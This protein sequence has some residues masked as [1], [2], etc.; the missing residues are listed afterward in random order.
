M[1]EIAIL[2]PRRGFTLIELLVVIAIIAVLIG[3]LL[4]AVQ[5]AREAARRAQ[6]INNMKQ[7]GLAVAN[8]ESAIGSYPASYGT[9]AGAAG[10]G[11]SGGSGTWG[12]WSP[13]SQLLPY[14]DQAALYNSI[15]FKLVSHGDANKAGDLAQVTAITTRIASLVCPSA[16]FPPQYFYSGAYPG[17]SYF[18]SV[19]SSLV[20]AGAT[21]SSAP[22]GIFMFGGGSDFNGNPTQGCPPL[23]I[24]DVID[25]TSNTIALGEWKLGDQ[26]P[27]KLS[28][29]DVIG[30]GPGYP[31]GLTDCTDWGSPLM[32]MQQQNYPAFQA[33][34]Q[35]CAGLAPAST[36]YGHAGWEY[37]MSYLGMAWNQG[38]FGWTL[39]N[40]LLA[41]N[42]PY[43]NCRCCSWN[44]DWDCPGMYGLSSFHPGGGNIAFADGSVRFLKS[45]TATFVVWALGSRAN[46]EVVSS[47]T[48]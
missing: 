2:K 29:Q 19:G 27:N 43:P 37:N 21:G 42:S 30:H 10:N 23:G 16:A 22:N 32:N 20:W 40:T 36:T 45:S 3:L 38:M 12:S 48:Y 7:V 18:A 8:Y 6:C 31:F 26:D 24:R 11:W 46:G 33:W 39:G 35:K 5:S 25:G 44:G 17:N 47:D 14:F 9:G 1:E 41:P 4:P 28:V 13:Q 34:L 15:N